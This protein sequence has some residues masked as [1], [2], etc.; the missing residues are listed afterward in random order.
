MRWLFMVVFLCGCLETAPIKREYVYTPS[1]TYIPTQKKYNFGNYV[2]NNEKDYKVLC[3][4][5]SV[6]V[7]YGAPDGGRAIYNINCDDQKVA[8]QLV[9]ASGSVHHLKPDFD[10]LEHTCLGCDS[11]KR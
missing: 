5:N 8:M 6:M 4:T 11:F 3:Y 1:Y 7:Y 10:Q 9:T 2:F